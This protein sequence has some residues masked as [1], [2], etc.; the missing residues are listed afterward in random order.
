MWPSSGP[1]GCVSSPVTLCSAG[2][3]ERLAIGILA[4]SQPGT[5]GI[6]PRKRATK[7]YLDASVQNLERPLQIRHQPRVRD[8][9]SATGGLTEAAAATNAVCL[10]ERRT[11]P[12][13]GRN[14]NPEG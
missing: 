1:S 8:L 13:A 14:L 5:Q 2:S 4:K 12:P 7:R 11:G 6:P 10:F 3:A 9:L